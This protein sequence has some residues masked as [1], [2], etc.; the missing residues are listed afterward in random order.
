MTHR[1][2]LFNGK[3]G[4]WPFIEHEPAL[5]SSKN[6]PR[7]TLVM[8]D[9]TIDRDVYW[10]LIANVIPARKACWPTG[11]KRVRIQ[12]DNARPH[13]TLD[14]PAVMAAACE[15]GWNM[16]MVS[17]PAQSPDTNALDLGFFASIQSLQQRK[18]A[19]SRED[20]LLNIYEAFRELRYEKIDRGFMTLQSVLREILKSG[21][22]NGFKIPHL[23][24]DAIPLVNGLLPL[25]LSC[26]QTA[27]DCALAVLEQRGII[28]ENDGALV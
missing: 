16:K 9:L 4:V 1:K 14:D 12:Q 26:E 21:G 23:H 11:H 8:K 28:L 19:R 2:C 24:K 13:V 20:L 27:I 3:V 15:G 7:G 5:R 10:L 25:S 6:R 18:V 22:G 17:Q